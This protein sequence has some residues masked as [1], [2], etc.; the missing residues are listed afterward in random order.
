VDAPTSY[1]LSYFRCPYCF[2]CSCSDKS[3][4]LRV[5]LN[6][7]T[8]LSSWY[9]SDMQRLIA[10]IRRMNPNHVLLAG[11]FGFLIIGLFL[12]DGKQALIDTYGAGGILALFVYAKAYCKKYRDVPRNITI[13]W[14]LVLLYF[15]VRTLFSDSVSY[16]ITTTMR[17]IMGYLTFTLF[18][19]YADDFFPK[20]FTQGLVPFSIIAMIASFFFLLFPQQTHILPLMNLLYAYYGHN[21][22]ANIL[23]IVYPIALLSLLKKH[24]PLHIGYFVLIVFSLIFTFSRGA[25]VLIGY[26]TI[27]QVGL[28]HPKKVSKKIIGILAIGILAISSIVVF[29]VI[30]NFAP[31]NPLANSRIAKQIIKTPLREEGRIQYWK[32]ALLTI[33]DHPLFGTGPGTFYLDSKRYQEAPDQYSWFAHNFVLQQL[34]EV[35]VMGTIPLTILIGITLYSLQKHKSF[36]TMSLFLILFNALFDFSLDFL[37]I[38]LFFWASLGMSNLKRKIQ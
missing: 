27:L 18:Y 8:L 26:Y 1:Y 3:V 30:T 17:M 24:T 19:E 11:F 15:I 9:D 32:Q 23:I 22:V 36:L 2:F 34:A 35:G 6:R 38:W 25:L 16:S 21:Y 31:N 4:Y 5:I 33:K 29:S 10:H 28:L 20:L 12:G 7:K 14:A 37:I 13:L